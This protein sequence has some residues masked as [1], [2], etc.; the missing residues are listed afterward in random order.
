MA[1]TKAIYLKAI[2]DVPAHENAEGISLYSASI[3]AEAIINSAD[4]ICQKLDDLARGE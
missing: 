3:I 2:N 1:N 4:K